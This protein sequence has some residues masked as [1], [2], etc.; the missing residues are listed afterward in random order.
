MNNIFFPGH[1][2]NV[3]RLYWQLQQTTKP[4]L[5]EVNR[6]LRNYLFVGH[7]NVP[8]NIYMQKAKLVSPYNYYFSGSS[9]GLTYASQYWKTV[10]DKNQNEHSNSLWGSQILWQKL[11]NI[12]SN[13]KKS[14]LLFPTYC[15][16]KHD[17]FLE[18]YTDKLVIASPN[19][20]LVAK[21]GA[22]KRYMSELYNEAGIQ[23]QKTFSYEKVEDIKES[24][25]YFV[26]QLSTSKLVIQVSQG[27]S[28]L[29]SKGNNAIYIIES[30]I[31]FLNAC[32]QLKNE[33]PVRI[34]AYYTGYNGNSSALVLPFATYVSCRP[35][36]KYCGSKEVRATFAASAGNQWSDDY[37]FFEIE[38]VYNRLIKVGKLMA[39]NN[40]FGI[41]GIDSI[42]GSHGVYDSEI[43]ARS[44]GP[45]MQ[46]EKAAI[47]A[48]LLSLYMLQLGY[49]LGIPANLFPNADSYNEV[50]KWLRVPS[51]IKLFCDK[52]FIAKSNINGKHTFKGYTVEITN[53]PVKGQLVKGD[54]GY[55]LGYMNFE[56]GRF[57]IF[58][59]NG[60][61]REDIAPFISSIYKLV[62]FI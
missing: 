27:A 48:G 9:N 12:I 29:T 62:G 13:S 45:D 33:G 16:K 15:R 22:D 21:Y 57:K 7:A 20:K 37:S 23:Y 34:V 35:S 31:E 5:Q 19:S 24:Y 42:I 32:K 2:V 3:T 26:N 28:G 60:E 44:Q 53:C 49:Y 43:N 8:R 50:T 1:P 25:F 6:R 59:E 10:E 51:Y 56:D 46:R 39:H 61:L 55:V 58:N 14:V 40:Y 11:E 4:F 18:T 54:Y 47:D 41:F 30:E 36:I 52:E 38:E 17:K